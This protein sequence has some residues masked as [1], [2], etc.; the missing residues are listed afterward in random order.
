M[1]P[2]TGRR[3][4]LVAAALVAVMCV[5]LQAASLSREKADL[6]SRKVGQ[7]TTTRQSG[8]QPRRTP[9]TEDELN[10]WFAFGARGTLPSSI[11]DPQVTLLPN[12]KVSGQAV[13]DLAAVG[14]NRGAL[15]LF[16]LLGGR[17][18]FTVTGVLRTSGGTGR[19]ELESAEVSGIPVPE[20][21]LQDVLSYY[22]RTAQ[23][24]EGVRLDQSFALPAAIKQIDVG[25]GQA[26]V[27]Q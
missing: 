12:G 21:L 8:V 17:V 18:P 11:A 20:S 4:T 7:I 6:F 24:P 3:A 15:D 22:S 23:H 16:S 13:V 19:F 26:V 10:S 2:F 1:R 25:L 14:R 5:R 9:I 27:I